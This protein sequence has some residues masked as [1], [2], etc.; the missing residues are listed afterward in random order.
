MHNNTEQYRDRPR[1]IGLGLMHFVGRTANRG[2]TTIEDYGNG[3]YWHR[4]AAQAEEMLLATTDQHA[5]R[6]REI[7]TLFTEQ[8]S[9]DAF[10]TAFERAAF[11]QICEIGAIPRDGVAS[12]ELRARRIHVE[13]AYLQKVATVLRSLRI[14]DL[15][16]GWTLAPRDEEPN[17]HTAPEGS[18]RDEAGVPIFNVYYRARPIG[19]SVG[20][21][22]LR[23]PVNEV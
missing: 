12:A 17:F 2:L 22:T 11:E 20:Y 19:E 4:R 6:W 13:P 10:I 9:T 3:A 5:R 14:I 1:T 16:H 7:T 21:V 8:G 15:P 23:K 18:I